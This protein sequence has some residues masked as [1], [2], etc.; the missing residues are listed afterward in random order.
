[1]LVCGILTSEPLE[2]QLQYEGVTMSCIYG[3][4]LLY[5]QCCM[6]TTE[7]YDNPSVF[8]NSTIIPKQTE[9]R[10]GLEAAAAITG[11]ADH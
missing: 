1:M 7:L 5:V 3:G 10:R 8:H 2:P 6:I 11:V 4:Q 9:N